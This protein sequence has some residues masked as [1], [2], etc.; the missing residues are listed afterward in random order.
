MKII[1]STLIHFF[2][3]AGSTTLFNYLTM[4]K[5]YIWN[6]YIG[7][8][9]WDH[10]YEWYHYGF[11]TAIFYSIA[12]SLFVSFAEKLFRKFLPTIL[13]YIVY[14]LIFTGSWMLIT[15]RISESYIF[16]FGNTWSVTEILHDII[17]TAPWFTFITLLLSCCIPPLLT[18]KI[19]TIKTDRPA[20]H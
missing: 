8:S 7:P 11:F 3:F 10:F 14:I 12:F 16:E 6:H 1:I 9:Q 19:F 13:F 4:G 5:G 2:V 20:L 18:K 17:F 15:F